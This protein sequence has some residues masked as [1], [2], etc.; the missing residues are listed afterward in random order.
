MFYCLI[1]CAGFS[2][3]L[4]TK[5]LPILPRRGKLGFPLIVIV[6]SPIG[7]Q[8]RALRNLSEPVG[9]IFL[10]PR[11]VCLDGSSSLGSSLPAVRVYFHLASTW[12][13]VIGRIGKGWFFIFV[14]GGIRFIRT[15][16]LGGRHTGPRILVFLC[17]FRNWSSGPYVF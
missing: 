13:P 4:V 11:W 1:L 8:L 14:L 6:L 17:F 3:G 7:F 5:T 10:L 9:L 12:L 15:F 2:F 16:V